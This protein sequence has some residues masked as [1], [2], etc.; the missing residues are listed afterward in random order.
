MNI[1]GVV[2]INFKALI[3]MALMFPM[4]VTYVIN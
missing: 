1:K 3:T 4:L 2:E